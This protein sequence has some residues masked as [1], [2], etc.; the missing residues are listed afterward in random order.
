M[1]RQ[2][3]LKRKHKPTVIQWRFYTV[4]G[5]VCL[6]FVTLLSRAAY[7]QVVEPDR[8]KREG[9]MRSLR[10]KTSELQRG[11]ILDRNGE[12]LAVSVPVKAIWVDPKVI[13][14]RG[15]LSDKRRWE[16][17]ADVLHIDGDT[18]IKRIESSPTKR[19]MYIKR[20]VTPGISEYVQKLKLPGVFQKSESRR[21]YPSGEVSAHI[22]G[23]TNIDAQGIEGIESSF[24]DW[25]N[26]SPEKRKI[27]KDRTGRTI[28][29]LGII[30]AREEPGDITLSIDQRIQALAYKEL[31][32]ATEYHGATSGSVVVI[33]VETGEILALA[34]TPSFNPNNRADRKPHRMRNRAITDTFEP[35]SSVKPM[36]V[37]GALANDVVTAT[38]TVNT[39]PGWMRIGGRAVR[40][41]KNYGEMTV[42]QILQK[43][44][45]IGVT[46]L[47]LA[48]EPNDLI[49]TFYKLGF[50]SSTETL[51]PGESNGFLSIRRKWS[52]F[53]LATLS[54]GYGMTITPIQLARAYAVLGS[55]GIKYPLSLIKRDSVPEGERVIDGRYVEQVVH[56][57]ESVTEKGGTGLKARVPGYRVA[58]KTGT[59]RKAI[60]GGYGE[61]YVADFAGIAPIS[62]PRLAIAVVINEP[63]GDQYYGGDVAAPVF[64]AV[65]AGALHYLNVPPDADTS[66]YAG[67][68]K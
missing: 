49:D 4:V 5:A 47:A 42:R 1:S 58:G 34:N 20:Q 39:S 11:T 21:F 36:V 56:M 17:L 61:D 14:D 7:I 37:L 25:L 55:G 8:L 44:S 54:F 33:D 50:G 62:Q 9:D 28:E 38:D 46:K 12:E 22:I 6:L 52:D 51:L 35:G 2:A 31:K 24:N 30:E 3:K 16:A 68:L 41:S 10:T 64:S 66:E 60:A 53:E 15:G 67:V 43:S 13:A 23:V 65:M 19:F 18:L 48:T 40:D 32:I 63:G 57:L 45:N 26:G 27:R 59:A 29:E